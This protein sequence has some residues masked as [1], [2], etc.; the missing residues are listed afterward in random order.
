MKYSF[1]KLFNQVNNKLMR[2]RNEKKN[3][4]QENPEKGKYNQLVVYIVRNLHLLPF[5]QVLVTICVILILFPRQILALIPPAKEEGKKRER[6]YY[7]VISRL[8]FQ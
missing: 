2:K 3:E 7:S 1:E 6:E 4:S 8:L 5:S